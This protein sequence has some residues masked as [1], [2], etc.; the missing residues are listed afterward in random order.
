MLLWLVLLVSRP[1][2][3]ILIF[4]I[5]NDYLRKSVCNESLLLEEGLSVAVGFLCLNCTWISKYCFP[6]ND[7][8]KMLHKTC[9]LGSTVFFNVGVISYSVPS[10]NSTDFV[11]PQSNRVQFIFSKTKLIRCLRTEIEEEIHLWGHDGLSCVELEWRLVSF[12]QDS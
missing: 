6:V 1:I 12:S 10:F 8:R 7:L 2:I 9:K 3:L 11:N 4:N 5:N